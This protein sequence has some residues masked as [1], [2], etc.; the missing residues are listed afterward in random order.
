MAFA[1]N[2]KLCDSPGFGSGHGY[3]EGAAEEMTLP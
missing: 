3:A 1:I 2:N